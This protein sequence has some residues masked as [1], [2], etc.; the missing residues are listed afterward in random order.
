[1]NSAHR[2]PRPAGG[3]QPCKIAPGN[4]DEPAT[5]PLGGAEALVGS[6]DCVAGHVLYDPRFLA[7]EFADPGIGTYGR[8]DRVLSLHLWLPPGLPEQPFG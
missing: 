8:W 6:C 4:F 5:C 7:R 2:G 3:F 1:M